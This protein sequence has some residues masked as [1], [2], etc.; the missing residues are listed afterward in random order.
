MLRRQMSYPTLGMRAV[1]LDFAPLK[2]PSLLRVPDLQTRG[3][4]AFL[5]GFS[6]R[7]WYCITAAAEMTFTHLSRFPSPRLPVARFD[8]ACFDGLNV[9]ALCENRGAFRQ[10]SVNRP[11][12]ASFLAVTQRATSWMIPKGTF[13]N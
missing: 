8:V 3:M 4:Q 6:D 9:P 2:V 12:S 5:A 10:A 1:I 11:I 7:L 13:K